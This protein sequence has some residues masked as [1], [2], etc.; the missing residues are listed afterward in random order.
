M[1]NEINKFIEWKATY[2]PRASVNYKSW[3]LRLDEEIK[4]PLEKIVL[5]DIVAFKNRLDSHYS[6]YT[7]QLAMVAVNNYFKFWRLQDVKCLQPELIKIPKTCAK[8]Y[9]AVSPEEYEKLIKAIPSFDFNS[10][11]NNLM[12]RLLWETGV[13]VS[14]LCDLDITDV[15]P[16][17]AQAVIRTK[18]TDRKRQIFWSEETHRLLLEYLK[19]RRI[20]NHSPA[21]FIGS[22]FSYTTK[23]L[24]TR[25]VQR[26]IKY[27]AERAGLEKKISP[28]SFRHGKAHSI[29][30]KGGTVKHIQ[31]ILGHSDKNP[32]ASFVYLQFDNKEME[33]YAKQ[34]L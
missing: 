26:M 33:K 23:R 9:Q 14:E 6:P 17:K 19:E 16:E 11:R 27:F 24:T 10:R 29:L 25:A 1:K 8:S 32:A 2:A 12:V 7:I 21:L 20:K 22:H 18:K 30:A 4:K 31:A 28:H 3:L 34:Y 15:D 13:R 5:D